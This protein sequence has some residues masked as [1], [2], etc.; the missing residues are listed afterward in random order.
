MQGQR[1][2]CTPYRFG[3]MELN[4]NGTVVGEDFSVVSTRHAGGGCR[5]FWSGHQRE[6]LV[7]PGGYGWGKPRPP[8]ARITFEGVKISRGPQH[9]WN[10]GHQGRG[11]NAEGAG[12]PRA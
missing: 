3:T 8:P 5:G 2:L 6:A 1:G 7:I 12:I 11:W 9:S 10:D 4:M